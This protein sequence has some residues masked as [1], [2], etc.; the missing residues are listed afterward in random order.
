MPNGL[1]FSEGSGSWGTA[2][3]REQGKRLDPDR[4]SLK[5]N[6]GDF[7]ESVAGGAGRSGPCKNSNGGDQGT[8]ARGRGVFFVIKGARGAE[9][10][11]TPSA[12][13]VV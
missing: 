2:T 5:K 12:E 6:I 9:R 8:G 11:E 3:R 7:I 1:V 13:G 4:G 10:G